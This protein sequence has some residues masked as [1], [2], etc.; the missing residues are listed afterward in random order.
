MDP[1]I[2]MLVPAGESGIIRRFAESEVVVI[3]VVVA[4]EVVVVAVAVVVVVDADLLHLAE[5]A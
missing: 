2:S 5:D 4:T 1:T 3:V